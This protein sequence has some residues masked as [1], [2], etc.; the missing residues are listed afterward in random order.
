MLAVLGPV[1]ALG[2]GLLVVFC[3]ITAKLGTTST[4]SPRAVMREIQTKQ[5]CDKSNKK[6]L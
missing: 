3:V 4:D 5:T 1:M 2:G 6:L